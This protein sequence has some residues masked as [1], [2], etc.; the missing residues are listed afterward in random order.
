MHDCC[1]HRCSLDS[2]NLER[3][4]KRAMLGLE[5]P[6]ES[7]P[8][9]VGITLLPYL[10]TNKMSKPYLKNQRFIKALS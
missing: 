6:E 3:V 9:E 10:Y 7:H 5:K 2:R 4:A 1:H 8:M